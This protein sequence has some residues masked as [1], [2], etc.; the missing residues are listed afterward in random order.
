M[1]QSIFKKPTDSILINGTLSSVQTCLGS[2]MGGIGVIYRAMECVSPE[3]QSHG[4][5]SG[6][7]TDDLA[8]LAIMSD[9]AVRG[10]LDGIGAVSKLLTAVLPSEISHDATITDAAWLLAGLTELGHDMLWANTCINELQAERL[11]AIKSQAG[12][13]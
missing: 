12:A 5:F 4:H 10:I 8:T 1:N 11:K 7:R 6:C 13:C 3:H 2:S 9:D